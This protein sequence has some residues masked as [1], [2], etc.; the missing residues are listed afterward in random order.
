MTTTA[1]KEV[2]TI[3]APNH[4]ATKRDKPAAKLF[5]LFHIISLIKKINGMQ[6]TSKSSLLSG[7]SCTCKIQPM[8]AEMKENQK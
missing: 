7:N 3:P 6:L 4:T 1:K 8:E 2:I 5:P